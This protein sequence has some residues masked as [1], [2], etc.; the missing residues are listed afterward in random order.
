MRS[1]QDCLDRYARLHR[2]APRAIQIVSTGFVPNGPFAF[3]RPPEHP[4]W[5]LSCILSQHRS[6]TC[7][8]GEKSLITS[9]EVYLGKE[10][11][12]E[13]IPDIEPIAPRLPNR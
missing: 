8:G 7:Q 12:Y 10:P 13:F 9:E 2:V 4:G 5:L 3:A 1:P 6:V 11:V